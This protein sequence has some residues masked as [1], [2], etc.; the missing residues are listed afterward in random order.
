MTLRRKYLFG[1]LGIILK[2]EISRFFL[3]NFGNKIELKYF[4]GIF[5]NEMKRE[6]FFGFFLNDS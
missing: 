1:F 2:W 3:N 4:C 6:R 5:E